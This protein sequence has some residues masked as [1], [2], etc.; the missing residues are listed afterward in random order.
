MSHQ[1]GEAM[2]GLGFPERALP[3]YRAL[4]TSAECFEPQA[5]TQLAACTRAVGDVR[6]ALGVY[7]GLVDGEDSQCL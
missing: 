7:Q 4:A 5:W 3:F 2:V 6:G 1:V